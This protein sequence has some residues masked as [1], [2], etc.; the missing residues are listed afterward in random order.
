MYIALHHGGLPTTDIARAKAFW[1]DTLKFVSCPAKSNW[2]GWDGVNYP[3]HLMPPESTAPSTGLSKH[4]AIEVAA[5]EPILAVLLGAGLAPFQAALTGERCPLND[6]NQSLDFGIG[7]IFLYDP[8]GN[9][10]EFVEKGRGI[11]AILG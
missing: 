6:I 5:L 8:D 3:I 9:V 7:T 10:I 4:I 1:C 2:L 11:F